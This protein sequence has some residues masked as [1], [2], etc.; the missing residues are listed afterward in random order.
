MADETAN[1]HELLD[2]PLSDFPERPTLPGLALFSGMLIGCTAGVSSQKGTPFLRF[3]VRLTDPGPSVPAS[4]MKLIS[5]AGFTLADYDV[6][7]EFYLTKNAMP[8]LRTFL[9]SIGLNESMSTKEQLKL[10]DTYSPTPETQEVVQGCE[11]VCQTQ[12]VG[13]NGRVYGRLEKI[14]GTVKK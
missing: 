10:D 1:F 3:D 7:G 9:L 2:A 14:A 6:W 4:A 5:D 11:V 13:S 12:A 8:M